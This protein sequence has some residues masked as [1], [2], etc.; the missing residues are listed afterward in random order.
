ML[1]HSLAVCSVLFFACADM[2][3]LIS[4]NES[5]DAYD[6]QLNDDSDDEDLN[7]K[8][9][10]NNISVDQ[11][12]SSTNSDDGSIDGNTDGK[13]DDNEGGGGSGSDSCEP[14]VEVLTKVEEI[15][16]PSVVTT[17]IDTTMELPTF[18]A[19]L[20][21][22][23]KVDLD[24]RVAVTGSIEHEHTYDDETCVII[25]QTNNLELTANLPGAP[26]SNSPN[27]IDD[28][29][30]Q[31][32]ILKACGTYDGVTDFSGSSYDIVEWESIFETQTQYDTFN[33]IELAPF[34]GND[35][36]STFGLEVFME[37]SGGASGGGNGS[38]RLRRY[39]ETWVTVTYEYE[40]TN[41]L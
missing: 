9:E 35:E 33:T 15:H 14:G 11:G 1:H 25:T 29:D 18:D 31:I 3:R 7:S 21:H 34:L 28:T 22:L 6:H 19:A 17:S 13:T 5:T 30:Q 23:T 41:C 27:L 4:S 20:G 37:G 32:A 39:S 36:E 8:K 26:D 10:D 12:G 2:D 16:L 38:T 40:Q 24:F